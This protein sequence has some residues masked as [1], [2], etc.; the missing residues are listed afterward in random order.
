MWKTLAPDMALKKML[1]IALGLC[2]AG[3]YLPY[4]YVA[5]RIER[6]KR[7][8]FVGVRKDLG[9]PAVMLFE[10]F[11][12][13]LGLGIEPPKVSWG[14]LAVDGQEAINPIRISWWLVVFPAGAMGSSLLAL[15]ILGDGLRDALD[16]KLRG[17]D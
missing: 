12:S 9:I 13:F 4:R 8:I 16:P 7:V 2:A 17:K 5:S 11:L 14:L 3:L 1:V 6:R 10:A 15:N